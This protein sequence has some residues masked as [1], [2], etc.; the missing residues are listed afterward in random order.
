MNAVLKL[1]NV[2]AIYTDIISEGTTK[3]YSYCVSSMVPP[4]AAYSHDGSKYLISPVTKTFLFTIINQ[5]YPLNSLPKSQNHVHFCIVLRW[6]VR[7]SERVS[8]ASNTKI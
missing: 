1:E 2:S 3:H 4:T 6:L 5:N 7:G 8:T